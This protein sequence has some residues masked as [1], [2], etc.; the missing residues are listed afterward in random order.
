MAPWTEDGFHD[1]DD[2]VEAAI[3][4]LTQTRL[5]TI[6]DIAE[7]LGASSTGS[8]RRT[9]SRWGVTAVARQPGRGGQNLFDPQQVRDAQ[10]ERPGRGKRT[11]LKTA[12]EI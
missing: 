8:A 4:R 7:H 5:W 2:A 3:E 6:A 10:A 9:L 11:D 12:E 1:F